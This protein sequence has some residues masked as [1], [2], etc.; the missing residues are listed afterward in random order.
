LNYTHAKHKYANLSDPGN[1]TYY[2]HS[3]DSNFYLRIKSQ[4]LPN[5]TYSTPN[6]VSKQHYDK[7]IRLSQPLNYSKR[8]QNPHLHS[9]LGGGPV[10]FAVNG[11]AMFS[12]LNADGYDVLNPPSGKHRALRA[13]LDMWLTCRGLAGVTKESF[14]ICD[15][16]PQ[17]E[18]VYHYHVPPVCLFGYHSSTNT[19]LV[20]PVG[21][22]ANSSFKAV[23]GDVANANNKKITAADFS[24]RMLIGIAFD[25]WPIYSPF[26]GSTVVDTCGGVIYGDKYAYYSSETTF[27]CTWLRAYANACLMHLCSQI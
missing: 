27:P 22:S 15:G 5:H 13:W 10:A 18:G 2:W 19:S 3:D 17:V 7:L 16:H 1:S 25:G 12:P 8:Y 21:N 6:T 9:T 14:D 26:N 11:V 20:Y 24:G 4:S 23:Y